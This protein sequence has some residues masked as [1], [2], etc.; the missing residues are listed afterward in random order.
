MVVLSTP[1]RRCR[2]R[3]LVLTEEREPVEVALFEAITEDCMVSGGRRSEEGDTAVG[4]AFEVG[5][6]QASNRLF[7]GGVDGKEDTWPGSD[8]AG[9]PLARDRVWNSLTAMM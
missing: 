6:P 4:D 1:S 2:F 7:R 9:Y 3:P 8:L 5:V